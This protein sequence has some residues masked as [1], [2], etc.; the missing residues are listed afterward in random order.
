MSSITIQEIA[1]LAGVSKSTVSRVISRPEMVNEETRRK[2]QKLID[3]N[4]FVPSFVAQNLAGHAS[5]II[6]IIIPELYNPFFLEIIEEAEKILSP[7]GYGFQIYSSK[8][9]MEKEKSYLIN[10]ISRKVDALIVAPTSIENMSLNLLKKSNIPYVLINTKMDENCLYTNDLKGGEIAAS[11][12]SSLKYEKLIVVSGFEHISIDERIN[13]LNKIQ[14]PPQKYYTNIKTFDEGLEFA[15]TILFKDIEN[16]PMIFVCNDNVAISVINGLEL[17]NK[18]ICRDY[19][20]LGYDDIKLASVCNL[21]TI[22][23]PIKEIGKQAAIVI[24]DMLENYKTVFKSQE[25]QPTLIC[26]K[27][28]KENIY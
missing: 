16:H 25:F 26:R 20:I 17:K 27:S 22:K 15:Q 28:T 1:K 21:S 7:L 8:W 6:G 18:Y 5:K 14:K 10:L 2:V 23:Q 24:L 12:I 4:H 9:D 3:N 19:Y 11:Y 13:N